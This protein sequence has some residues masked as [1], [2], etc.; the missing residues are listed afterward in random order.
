MTELICIVCPK[1]CHLHVDEKNGYTVTG[2]A[3]PRGA[4]YGKKELLHPTRT[5]T[6]TVRI[7]GASIPRV[8]VK[9][10]R[11]IP[12]EDIFAAMKL[13]DSVTL[14]APVHVGDIVVANILGLD[15][16]FVVTRS[17]EQ[18]TDSD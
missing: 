12:K 14:Q 9:T 3:C 13:L 5:I 8:P 4:I 1:G 6:S 7:E 17:L 10:D 18:A 11:D 15:A 16:N 2:N